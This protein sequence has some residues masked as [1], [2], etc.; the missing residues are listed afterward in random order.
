MMPVNISPVLGGVHVTAFA[1]AATV[2]GGALFRRPAGRYQ[3]QRREFRAYLFYRPRSI[4]PGGDVDYLRAAFDALLYALRAERCDDYRYIHRLRESAQHFIGGGG[5]DDDAA[6][7]LHLGEHREVY[8]PAPLREPAAHAREDRDIRGE[9]DGLRYPRLGR[10]GIHREHGVRVHVADDAH[11]CSK[12]KGSYSFAE[13]DYA[14]RRADALGHAQGEF[15]QRPVYLRR[16]GAR[17]GEGRLRG[18]LLCL[19]RALAARHVSAYF[20]AHSVRLRFFPGLFVRDIIHEDCGA[21]VNK[22]RN[23]AKA[24]RAVY[25]IPEASAFAARQAGARPGAL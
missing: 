20:S 2:G 1:P 21:G 7:A 9:H 19:L 16:A 4:R 13:N 10:E 3:R 14:A 11:I 15:A 24:R 18:R 25:N 23:V 6:R 12:N 17:S 8:H 5:V 22:G